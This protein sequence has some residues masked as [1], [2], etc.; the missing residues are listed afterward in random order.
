ML[1]KVKFWMIQGKMGI[2]TQYNL[3][4]ASFP[5]KVINKKNLSNAI[6]QFKKQAKSNKNNACQ[7][8][9]ELYLNKEDD[10]RWI[11]KPCFDFEERRLNSLFWMSP[12]QVNSYGRYHDIVI[13]DTTSKTNQFDMILM[14]II[15]VDNNFRNLIVAA[16]ILEDETEATFAWVLQ[17]LK[18]SCDIAPTALYSD[19][20]PALI[21]A[22]RK[23]YPETRHFHCIFHID[24]NLRKK[25]KGKL[26]DQFEYFRTKFLTM[27]NSLCHKK[28][29]IEWK[30]LINEFPACEQY[31]TRVL[32]SCK[33]SWASYAVNRNFTAGIQSTQRAEV[34]N[35]IIKD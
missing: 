1:E 23:N 2:P 12:N 11:I 34:T 13:I 15:V 30:A 20:D 7:M 26:H 16:A 5:G 10:P 9:T 28:F 3:L 24:L 31:L 17:E 18:N 32:Y 6:Q 4:V 27:C 35:K 25:L 14:L 22:V 33:H 29:E 8:L 19:A 21:S